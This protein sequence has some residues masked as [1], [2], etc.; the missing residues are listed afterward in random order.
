MREKFSGYHD[1]KLA[2]RQGLDVSE[3]QELLVGSYKCEVKKECCSGQDSIGG[4]PIKRELP[5]G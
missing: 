4:I 2:I 1:W 5:C 3:S